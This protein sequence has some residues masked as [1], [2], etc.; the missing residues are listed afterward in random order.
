MGLAHSI[1]IYLFRNFYQ[2]NYKQHK[3]VHIRI[4]WS[5]S[6]HKK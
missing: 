3:L 2:V 5:E 1:L 6:N 4:R